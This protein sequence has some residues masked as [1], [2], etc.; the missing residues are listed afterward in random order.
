MQTSC[1]GGFPCRRQGP[2]ERERNRVVIEELVTERV[3]ATVICSGAMQTVDADL[4]R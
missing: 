3:G 2:S 4:S 1:L